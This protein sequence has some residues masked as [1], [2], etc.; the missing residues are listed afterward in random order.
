MAY[1]TLNL[2]TDV[3]L[4][5][6]VLADQETPTASQSAGALVKLIDLIDS[7]NLDPQ[8][9]YGATQRILPMVANQASYTIGA[10]GDLNITRP[11]IVTSAYMRNTSY[12]AAQQQ[13]MPMAVLTNEQWANLPNKGVTGSYPYAVWFDM[14]YPLVTA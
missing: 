6:G 4:D 9:I 5:M 11:N 7:W 8:R 1:T 14:T 10:G 3:L 12:P 2:I 13:D